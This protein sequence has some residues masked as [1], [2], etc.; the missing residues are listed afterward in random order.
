M[1]AYAQFL[2][3]MQREAADVALLLQTLDRETAAIASGDGQALEAA[4]A[5]KQELLPRLEQAASERAALLAA[6]GHTPN[7]EGL[8]AY[9]AAATATAGD[10][11]AGNLN[12]TWA[13]LREQ[14]EACQNKNMA[15]GQALE[16]S[17]RQTE[18]ALSLLLGQKV[19]GDTTLYGSDGGTVKTRGNHSY[20]KV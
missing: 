9:F 16:G 10:E 15:N 1:Q 17:R 8:E 5:A 11:L 3:L 2:Q 7:R 14:L 20:A 4:A 6:A 18:Q 12:T 19:Q 13:A